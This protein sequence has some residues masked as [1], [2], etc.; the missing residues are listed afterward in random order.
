MNK[1]HKFIV[2]KSCGCAFSE[3][4]L[5]ECPSENCLVCGKPFQK[6]DII[7]LN[8]DEAELAVLKEKLKE[9]KKVIYFI[10]IIN[11]Y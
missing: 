2:I 9:M 5:K 10:I 11:D 1:S 7:P 4:S 6:E 3:K 8:P